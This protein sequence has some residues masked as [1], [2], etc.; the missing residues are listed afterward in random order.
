[1]QGFSQEVS[2]DQHRT[3]CKDN[4][5]VKVEMP[6][7]PIVTFRDGQNQFRVPFIMYADFESILKPIKSVT[8]DPNQ[9]YTNRVSEHIPS[10][11][12]VYSKFAYGEVSDLLN[13]YRGK[14]CIRT[15]CKYIK[16]KGYSMY[17]EFPE[18]PMLPL[19]HKRAK[20]YKEAKK[21]HICKKLFNAG[22]YKVR[23]HCHYTSKYRG[24][25]HLLCNL[26]YK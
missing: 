26:R 22:N 11:W 19:T 4:E 8:P 17:H 9:P 15:F 7:D 16:E 14:D 3:Y 12:C 21:C 25:A 18:K 2:Q 13:I 20:E 1:M 5:T 24:P 10:V 23:D 6:K